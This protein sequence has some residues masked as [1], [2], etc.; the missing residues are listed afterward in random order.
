MH[1]LPTRLWL[2]AAAGLLLVSVVA[3]T[4][5]AQDGPV[6]LS[7]PEDTAPLAPVVSNAGFECYL[8]FHPQPG[9]NGLVPNGWTGV[10]L[11][12]NPTLNSTRWEFTGECGNDG[13]VE[14][15][16]GLD[17]MVFLSRDIETPPQPGKS[18][19]ATVY[20]RVAVVPG[21]DYSLSGWMVS[22]CGGSAT[23]NDCPRGYFIAKMLGID[24]TGG[25]DP[26]APG[27]IWIEDR[28]NFTE[29]RWANLRMGVTAQ[30]PAITLF[31]RIRSPYRW[32]GAHAF[33]D[34]FS[35][36]RAPTAHFV[37][38]PSIVNGTQTIVRW[39]G[40]QSPDI[41]AI[42]GGTYRLMFDVQYR[43]VDQDAWIDWRVGQ[44]AGQATFIAGPC[45][46][47]RSFQFRLRARSEQPDGSGGASPNHRYPGPWSQ[48]VFIVFLPGS[49]H[50][51]RALL[52]LVVK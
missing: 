4:V 15:L 39:G 9:I 18:F 3:S 47:P 1:H 22:L 19:D 32:H 13:F 34:A 11:Y 14:R 49:T 30:G 35:L 24:P 40:S 12:D 25:I 10:L 27:V 29:S 37:D 36:M 46:A 43:Q 31:A 23:P 21:T 44:P 28:R 16:E 48:P 26:Q 17:S 45:C 38:L 2:A 50:S 20:Q 5:M 6:H 7:G 51:P 42:P 52:P 33:V 41:V 8:G